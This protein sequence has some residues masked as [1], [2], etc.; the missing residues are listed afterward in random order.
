MRIFFCFCL[1][2]IAVLVKA[3]DKTLDYYINAGMQTSPL[4]KDYANQVRLNHIDSARLAAEYKPQVNGLSTNSWAPVVNG[5]GY[6]G[7]IS[8]YANFSELVSGSQQ[9]TGKANLKNQFNGISLQSDSVRALSRISEQDL[10]KSITAQYITAYGSWQQYQFNIDVYNLLAREDTILKKLTQATVYKQT[11]YLTF[12][13]TLHQQ[14]LTILQARNQFRN[15]FASLNYVSG[16]FDT[17]LT[18]LAIPDIQLNNILEPD[19]TVFYEKFR[20]DSLLLR[21]S[22]A[23]I[24]FS[25]KPKINLYADAGYVSSFTFQAYKNFGSSIGINLS[26]PIYDGKQRKMLHTKISI[27]EQT[28][29]NYR[30]Y[31]KTQ[32]SQ[33]IAQL[34]QQLQS[35]QELIN[36]TTDQLKY[37]EGL[38][39]A[40]GK[41]LAT[42]DVHI[43]DYVIAINN[44]LSAKNIILQN[45]IT[46]LQIITQINYWNRK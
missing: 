25:Y 21:N 45:T 6:D 34:T 2:I 42:G 36:E 12:L 29:Q 15:D 37:V 43:A 5:W 20:I 31:F 40:N 24:D 16:L 38:I 22:D 17:S 46:K 14:K 8:N 44:Y 1:I 19:G 7:S 28:R 23:Q 30:D 27:A 9:L 13:V 3:Q 11:D 32:Y 35:V 18:A 26:V 4:F 33:Q 39:E 41:L 10:K